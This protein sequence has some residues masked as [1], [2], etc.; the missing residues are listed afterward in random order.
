MMLYLS[1]IFA[2]DYQTMLMLSQVNILYVEAAGVI[3]AFNFA[4]P[5]SARIEINRQF[6]DH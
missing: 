6:T 5:R 4:T 3:D 2:G 1:R